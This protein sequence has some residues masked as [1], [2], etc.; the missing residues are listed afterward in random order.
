MAQ[1]KVLKS[2]NVGT[3]GHSKTAFGATPFL[4]RGAGLLLFGAVAALNKE[5]KKFH[6]DKNPEH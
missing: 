4:T 2:Q 6:H 3:V 1:A 5:A